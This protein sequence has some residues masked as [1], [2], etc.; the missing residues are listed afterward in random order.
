MLI[1]SHSHIEMKAFDGDRDQVVA[2]AKDVGVDYIIAVGI[3]LE[4]CKRVVSITK[5]YKT[6]YGVI[7]IHPHHAKDI[8]NKTYDSLRQMVHNDKIVAYGE[9]GLDFF[10]NLSPR[11]TQIKRFGEQLELASEVGLPVVIHDREAHAQ[12]M[13][14]LEQW[15]GDKRGIIHCFSGDYG[16][17]R[18]CL[19]MGFYIS[20]PGTITFKNSH[21]LRDVVKKVPMNRLLVETDAPFL[22]PQQKRGGRNE[23]AYVMYTALRIAEIKGVPVEEVEEITYKNT[24][25]VFGIKPV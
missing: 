8:D 25:D 24:L 17:A 11:N 6:V 16:M 10:R 14:I 22:T 2:R 4:D 13:N 3:S 19:D 9:I 7:G 15:K 5:Q 1:D 20:I 21:Q 12:T 18:K 23:P